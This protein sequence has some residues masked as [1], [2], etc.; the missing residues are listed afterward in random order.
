MKMYSLELLLWAT[1]YQ[2]ILV[3]WLKLLIN[4]SNVIF[5]F[6]MIKE[7]MKRCISSLRVCTRSVIPSV[8]NFLNTISG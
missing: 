2:I 6:K 4:V 7:H 1:V 3:H 5:Y 8:N